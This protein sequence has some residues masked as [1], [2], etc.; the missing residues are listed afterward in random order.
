MSRFILALTALLIC[1]G[2]NC[3]V[4]EDERSNPRDP[5]YNAGGDKSDL[6]IS[7]FNTADSYTSN[8]PYSLQVTVKNQGASAAG[9]FTIAI[10]TG[11]NTSSLNYALGYST[12]FAGKTI[13]NSLPANTSVTVSISFTPVFTAHGLIGAYADM[14]ETVAESNEAN[15]YKINNVIIN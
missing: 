12:S 1:A 14:T 3:S 5:K 13:V 8:Q 6:V 4:T 15:N 11:S 9:S 2:S 10:F 7:T